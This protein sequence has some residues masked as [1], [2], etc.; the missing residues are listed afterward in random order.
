MKVPDP[1]VLVALEKSQS[2]LSALQSQILNLQQEKSDLHGKVSQLTSDLSESEL[3]I[4]ELESELTNMSPR[5]DAVDSV[6]VISQVSGCDPA[7]HM[8]VR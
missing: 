4:H 3:R 7:I 1:T 2:E 8:F 5:G 6:V